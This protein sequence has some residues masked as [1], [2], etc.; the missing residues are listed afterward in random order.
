MNFVTGGQTIIG[1]V[2]ESI[3]EYLYKNKL[4]SVSNSLKSEIEKI[5]YATERDLYKQVELIRKIRV[6]LLDA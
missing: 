1:W 4:D 3:M 6:D 2:E 5:L